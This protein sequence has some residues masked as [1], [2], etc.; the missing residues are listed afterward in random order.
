MRQLI[1]NVKEFNSR[2]QLNVKVVSS[3]NYRK[4]KFRTMRVTFRNF[5]SNA[6]ATRETRIFTTL[7]RSGYIRFH[8]SLRW[9]HCEDNCLTHPP[10]MSNVKSLHCAIYNYTQ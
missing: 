6:I 1:G 3:L 10:E 2:P 4:M 9:Q 8:L 7:F 5:R